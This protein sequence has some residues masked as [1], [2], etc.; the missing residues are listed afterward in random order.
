MLYYLYFV[1]SVVCILIHVIREPTDMFLVI[2]IIYSSIYYIYDILY[3]VYSVVC[4]VIHVISEPT[5]MFW[6]L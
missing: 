2:I 5:E 1:Y 3:Y 6:R 4:I